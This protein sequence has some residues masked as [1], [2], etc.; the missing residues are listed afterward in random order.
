M[1]DTGYVTEVRTS[2]LTS[3]G[4][5][6]ILSISGGV[7]E[8]VDD[9][10]VRLP[11]S[12]GYAVEVEYDR[13]S[14]T[15]TVRRTFTRR[16]KRTADNPRPEPVRTVK[17]EVTDVYFDELGETAYRAGMFRSYGFGE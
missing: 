14:D 1:T 8:W 11:V 17:G 5:W 3:I 6:N 12:N 9:F 7:V 15:Y 4:R 13:G 10:T 2:M 16:P